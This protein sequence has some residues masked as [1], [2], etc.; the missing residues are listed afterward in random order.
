MTISNEALKRISARCAS[1]WDRFY[2]P[3]KLRTDPVYGAVLDEVS[4]STLPLLDIGCGIGLLTQFLR[5]HGH[6]VPMIGFDYDEAKIER[7]KQM[8]ADFENVG[9]SVGDARRDLPE[10][11]GHVIILDILQF[12]VPEEQD[13]LLREAARRVSEH[14]KLIIRSGVCDDSWRHKVTIAGDVL[15]KATQWMKSGPVCYPTTEQFQR[16]LGEAGL[17][18]RVKPL[19]G[20]T[21]F[22]NHLIVGER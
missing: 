12:F 1:R 21:P 9:F 6:S 20:G 15:A 7:A 17:K 11:N 8:A 10:H 2:V 3:S 4:G 22:N 19:W 5:E 18:V 16:V 14:G 13:S